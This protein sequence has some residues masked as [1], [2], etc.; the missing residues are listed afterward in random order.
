MLKQGGQMLAKRDIPEAI[1][2]EELDKVIK[3]LKKKKSPDLEG[4]RMNGLKREEKMS[5]KVR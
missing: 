1:T 2:L 3:T 5:G 4:W